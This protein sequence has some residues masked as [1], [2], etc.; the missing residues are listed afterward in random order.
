[1]EIIGNCYCLDICGSKVVACKT[2]A[3]VACKTEAFKQFRIM[4]SYFFSLETPAINKI[5][6]KSCVLAKVTK[7]RFRMCMFAFWWDV[8]SR[9]GVFQ[10]IVNILTLSVLS[11]KSR[12][13]AEHA[14]HLTW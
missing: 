4:Y 10:I 3:F 8:A 14:C 1:M 11:R 5:L 12:W 6:H 7:L 9:A 13:L 2:E